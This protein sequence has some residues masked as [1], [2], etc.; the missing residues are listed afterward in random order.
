MKDKDDWRPLIEGNPLRA[1]IH[2]R[3]NLREQGINAPLPPFMGFFLTRDREAVRIGFETAALVAIC[4]RET[5]QEQVQF[6]VG[7]NEDKDA[8]EHAILDLATVDGASVH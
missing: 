7:V 4:L 6:F 8:F 5:P 1:D 3:A 2:T